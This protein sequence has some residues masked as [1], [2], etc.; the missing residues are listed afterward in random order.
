MP[1]RKK[2]LLV[3]GGTSDIAK[4]TAFTFAEKG[5]NVTISGRE[6]PVAQ[7]EA[8]NLELR[9]PGSAITAVALDILDTA[10]FPSFL[11]GLPVLPDAV[12]L[13]VGLLGDQAL[14]ERS[15]DHATLVMRSN[16]EGPC[17][18]LGLIASRFEERGSGTI[19]GISS[20]AGDRGR[21]SNYVYGAAKAG[22]TAFLSGLRNRL[23]VKGVH[24]LTVKPGFVRTRMTAGMTLPAALTAA[25]QE[26]AV[27][28]YSAVEKRRNVIYVRPAWRLIMTIIKSIPEG[29][30]KKLRL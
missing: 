22:L 27:A 6:L 25:P 7:A 5:W 3:V 14:A 1:P 16:F 26:L 2:S 28:I 18:L 4:A 8:A 19:I 15:F 13:A 17:L 30:F 12:L 24:V 11:D 23:A 9:M 20:V 29:L 21:A 10:S